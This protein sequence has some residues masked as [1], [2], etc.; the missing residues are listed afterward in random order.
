MAN[1]QIPILW[2]RNHPISNVLDVGLFCCMTTF[3]Y[4]TLFSTTVIVIIS[5]SGLQFLFQPLNFLILLPYQPL[6]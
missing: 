2:L 5:G 6:Q 1:S 4:I 3:H